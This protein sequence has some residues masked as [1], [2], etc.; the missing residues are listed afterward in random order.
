MR[1][2]ESLNKNI[3]ESGVGGISNKFKIKK[4]R[5]ILFFEDIIAN[6]VKE[7]EKNGHRNE[8]LIVGEK[9]LCISLYQTIHPL[10]KKFPMLF[11][12]SILKKLWVNLGLVDNLAVSMENGRAIIITENEA[13]TRIIGRNSIMTGS[14]KGI[15]EVV[16][17]S[18]VNVSSVSQNKKNCKYVF[19]ITNKPFIPMASKRKDLYDRLNRNPN[20]KGLN[21]RDA[22]KGGLIN[23]DENNKVLFRGKYT[24]MG[25]TTLLHLMGNLGIMLDRLPVI[26]YEYFK[27]IVRDESTPERK[28]ILIKTLLQTM[29]WG[30]V[31]ILKSKGVVKLEIK[32]PPHGIQ[33]EKDNWRFLIETFL[34]YLWLIDKRFKIKSDSTSQQKLSVTYSI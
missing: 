19:N 1:L 2:T 11:L 10:F 21:L 28:L 31:N 25:E 34:G 20:I 3:L 30:Q 23:V 33:T 5:D 14:Y 24:I 7:C 4:R 17:D 6:Y 13:I 18:E 32:Y 16:L 26:S 8:M 22:L 9:W 29:G 15:L 27:E 12:N